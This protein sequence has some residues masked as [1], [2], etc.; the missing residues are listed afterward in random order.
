[1]DFEGFYLT[2]AVWGPLSGG[3]KSEPSSSDAAPKHVSAGLKPEVPTQK[4][5]R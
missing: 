5:F 1:M 3:G 2:I 4:G